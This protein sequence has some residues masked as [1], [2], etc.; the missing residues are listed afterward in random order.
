MNIKKISNKGFSRSEA[1][2]IL[3][4]ITL[5]FTLGMNSLYGVNRKKHTSICMYNLNL[6][7]KAVNQFKN[8]K[9]NRYPWNVKVKEGGSADFLGKYKENYKHWLVLGEYLTSPRI[10]KC[11]SDKKV[12][13]NSWSISKPDDWN[14]NEKF[15]PVTNQS[16]G[17]TIASE[18]DPKKI[19][20][21]NEIIFSDRNIVFGKYNNDMDSKGAIKKLGKKFTGRNTVRWT[22][23]NHGNSGI[24]LLGNGNAEFINSKGLEIELVQNSRR[25]N[26]F[27][28][29]AGK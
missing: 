22:S 26:E 12:A 5:M 21:E 11:S 14:V 25:E 28:F 4:T 8:D 18:S 7:Y 29:P 2:A 3:I 10:L 13:A 16:V 6:V 23:S 19:N 1:L 20:G 9:E 27:L 24:I 15:V 17:Y